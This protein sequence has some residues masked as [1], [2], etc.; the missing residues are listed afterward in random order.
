MEKSAIKVEVEKESCQSCYF[1]VIDTYGICCK[2][3]LSEV[4]LNEVTAALE[5]RVLAS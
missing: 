5:S 4:H 3:F 2:V 1:D